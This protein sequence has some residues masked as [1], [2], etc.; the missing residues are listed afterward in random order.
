MSKAKKIIIIFFI[1]CLSACSF[2]TVSANS[3]NSVYYSSYS[4]PQVTPNS[5]YLEVVTANGRHWVIQCFVS[6]SVFANS[7]SPVFK[8]I[9][10]DNQLCIFVSPSAMTPAD[11]TKDY[12]LLMYGIFTNIDTHSTGSMAVA[13]DTSIQENGKLCRISLANAGNVIK[14]HGYNCDTSYITDNGDFTFVYGSDTVLNQK[15]NIINNTL[16]SIDTNTGL[17]SDK[18]TSLVSA[19]IET[20]ANLDEIQSIIQNEGNLTRDSLDEREII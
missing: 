3:S 10:K 1:V 9:V 4:Q 17:T 12:S 8:A 2:F 6:S 7:L 16:S 20:N 13:S 15:I 19:V 5:C 11:D 14:I 18:L